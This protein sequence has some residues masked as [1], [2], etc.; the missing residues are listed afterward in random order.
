MCS[1]GF[2]RRGP[3][4]LKGSHQSKAAWAQTIARFQCQL[5]QPGHEPAG[6]EIVR[7]D[8]RKDSLIENSE[9]GAAESV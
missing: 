9:R 2:E 3:G 7:L 5:L 8:L 6:I 1:S 4:A